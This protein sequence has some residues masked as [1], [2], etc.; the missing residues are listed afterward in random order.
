LCF[1]KDF[2]NTLKNSL[3]SYEYLENKIKE[4]LGDFKPLIAK[5]VAKRICN[6]NY[7]KNDPI[8]ANLKNIVKNK[9]LN[10]LKKYLKVKKRYKH[11]IKM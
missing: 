2:E 5:E 7:K 9:K 3:G 4:D 10:M 11:Q 8:L 6:Q 1:G